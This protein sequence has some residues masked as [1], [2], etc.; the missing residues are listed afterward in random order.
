MQ[1]TDSRGSTDK[2]QENQRKR[3]E[4]SAQHALVVGFFLLIL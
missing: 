3:V 1:A 4:F 2:K